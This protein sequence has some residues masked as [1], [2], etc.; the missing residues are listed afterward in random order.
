MYHM[1]IFMSWEMKQHFNNSKCGQFLYE[2]CA[3]EVSIIVRIT[4]AF[5]HVISSNH[6]LLSHIKS[7]TLDASICSVSVL[8]RFQIDRFDARQV[9]WLYKKD[10]M[11]IIII[12]IIIN[13][14]HCLSSPATHLHACKQI[15]FTEIRLYRHT[16][17]FQTD[18]GT[19]FVL[20]SSSMPAD[21]FKSMNFPLVP[22]ARFIYSIIWH[23]HYSLFS[24]PERFSRI[25]LH[26][27]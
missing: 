17:P 12:I 20:Y 16:Q 2:I 10:E 22:W 3:F 4:T 13:R 9:I 21:T 15:V 7:N 11:I 14:I 1:L 23:L 27:L 25:L 18:F 26:I 6:L 24:G 19:V 5:S 8:F